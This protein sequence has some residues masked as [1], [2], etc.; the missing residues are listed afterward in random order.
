ME[1]SF[2]QSNL[3]HCSAA[4]DLTAQYMVEEKVD[5]ALL[6]DTYRVDTSS[7]AWLASSGLNKAAIYI[8]SDRVTVANVIVDPEFV[9]ARINGVQV[10]SCY[11][12]PNQPLAGFTLFLQRLENSIRTISRGAPILVTGDFNA[13]SAAWGDWIS[14]GRG[15]ELGLMLES[16]DLVII[17]SGSTPTFSRGA[18]SIIDLTIASESLAGRTSNWRVMDQVFNNS[19]HHFIR[20][21]IS[22]N[23]VHQPLPTAG[24]PRGWNTSGGIDVE[25]LHTGLLIAEWLDGGPHAD[26]NDAE[27]GALSLRSRIISACDFSLP[28]RRAPKPGKPPVHWWN[29]E[30]SNLRAE[31][32]R[33]KRK[34]VRMVARV[35]RLR[36]RANAD[37]DNDRATS[38]LERTNS[39]FVEAKRRLKHAISRS[40]KACWGELIASVDQDPF[41]KPY[42]MVMRKLRGPPATATMEPETLQTVV[43]TLFP[44]HQQRQ[45]EVSEQPVVWEPFTQR[46]VDCAVTKF[47]GRNRAPGPDGITT[48]IIWAVHRCDPGLLLSLYNACLRSGTFPEQWKESRVVLLRKGGKPEGVPSSYRPL[49]LLNDL[50]KFLSGHGC[51]G[52]YLYKLQKVETAECV[53]CGAVMDNAEHA[54]FSSDRWW[55]QGRELEG[56]INNDFTPQT[57]CGVMLESMHNWLAVSKYLPPDV[58]IIAFA[59][60]VALLATASVPFLLEERLEQALGDVVDWLT[61]NGLELAIEKSEAVLLTNRNKHNRMTKRF[62]GHLFES[63]PAVKYL[64]VSID[65]RLHFREHAE[66]VSKR[67][68]DTC[69]YLTPIHPNLRGPS[70]FFCV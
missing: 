24:I 10:Y 22:E 51:F 34:K 3:N 36:Q 68:S 5:I 38:E 53:D 62:Q 61:A 40:K 13:R 15:D 67:A 4:Q 65:P 8:A 11:A 2:I 12:S 33:A 70:F 37:F 9:S 25:A 64:G 32:V 27:S 7:N 6:S 63:K 59:D 55:R 20:F 57:F 17:N 16:L 26:S 41:G 28:R 50:G 43:S 42:K 69:H 14:N 18:G 47:K 44:T 45:A 49:C 58:V 56:S 66:L 30:I 35:A 31:C 52:T 48:K 19:D 23:L 29:T 39:V 46:E 54:F 21:T 60:D 1:L